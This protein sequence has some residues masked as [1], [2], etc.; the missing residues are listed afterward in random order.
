M[1]LQTLL[2]SIEALEIKGD[3]G[4]DVT[5]IESD[6]RKVARGILFVA[7]RGTVVDGHTFINMAVENG[8]VAIVCEEMPE[9]ADLMGNLTFIRVKD[10]AFA[11]GMMLSSWYGNPSQQL[12]LVGVTGTN[13]KTTIATLLYDM[14]RKLGHKAG[15][16]STVCNYID[17]KPV[18]T[19]HTTPDPIT[20]HR[21]I[22]QMKKEECEYVF[23][24][25]SSHSIDQN[26]QIILRRIQLRFID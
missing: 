10:S 12:V 9:K 2:T 11:L 3:I 25:V 19:D 8:A 22:A 6:S 20:L 4:I 18:P 26:R 14:F 13:G 24:E 5:G 17:G 21:L 15:L 16:L 23:M 1:E 7:V